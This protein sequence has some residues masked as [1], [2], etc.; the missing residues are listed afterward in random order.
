[1]LKKIDE[2]F[3]KLDKKIFYLS[4]EKVLRYYRAEF[5]TCFACICIL[6][7][8]YFSWKTEQV[9]LSAESVN[10]SLLITALFAV[11]GVIFVFKWFGDFRRSRAKGKSAS[12]YGEESTVPQETYADGEN[13]VVTSAKVFLALIFVYIAV[14]LFLWILGCILGY[15]RS[16]GESLNL[17]L[18]LDSPNYLHIAEHWY[19]GEGE[20]QDVLR[21]VFFPGYP[22]LIK[23]VQFVV[24]DYFLASLLVSVFCFAA[25]GSMLYLLVR[26]DE[27][28]ETALRAVKFMCLVPGAFFFVA[29]MTESL[30]LYTTVSAVYFARRK[31]Y[32]PSVLFGFYAAFTRSLGIIIIV[33]VVYELIKQTLEERPSGKPAVI[34]CIR[35]F[36]SVLI[37]PC[38]LGAYL[39][40]N[41]LVTGDAFKF[42]EY[43]KS[44][45]YQEMSFFFNTASYETAQF[46]D[47]IENGEVQVGFALWGM[48]LCALFGTLIMLIISSKKMRTSYIAYSIVY[49]VAAM[50]ATW[51]LSG[52]RYVAA[53]FTL[54]LTFTF[55]TKNKKADDVLTVI[56]IIVYVIYSVM[57][58]NRWQVW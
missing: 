11:L 39:L 30:F 4:D 44:H 6:F 35:N 50:G 42:L 8:M 54:P 55:I 1:M 3:E 52:P 17:L 5:F 45:W 21:I 41:K 31:M 56:L 10:A 47:K 9:N 40:I 2:A 22:I 57:F 49:Y 20:L 28:K 13:R 24:R 43:Q 23:L 19:T 26:L 36:I 38:G 12:L 46:L 27:S 7:G 15:Y 33:P 51:L 37:I 48:G 14:L 16:L 32:L 34:K 25:A 53:M 58:I 29:P 18:S